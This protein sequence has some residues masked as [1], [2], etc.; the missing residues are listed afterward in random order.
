MHNLIQCYI[1]S[2]NAESRVTC[3]QAPK[4]SGACLFSPPGRA[5]LA[6]LADFLC[7]PATLDS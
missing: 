3:E 7:R 1:L 4:C 6:S 5:R 2:N